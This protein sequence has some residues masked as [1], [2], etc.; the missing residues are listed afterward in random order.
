MPNSSFVA[1]HNLWTESQHE[2]AKKLLRQ[3]KD[4]GIHTVRVA[5]PDQHGILRGKTFTSAVFEQLL[6]DGVG[7][8]STILLKDTSHRTVFSIWGDA[9][10]PTLEALTGAADVQ[11]I[12]DPD[13]FRVLPWRD[14]TGW[15]ISD[16]YFKDGTPVPFATRAVLKNAL[17][18]LS[19][20]GYEFFS[21]IEL[22]F[23]VYRLQDAKLQHSDC[24][25]PPTPPDVQPIAHGFN[26]L[27]ESVFDQL[28]DV[29]QL[30]RSTL[31]KLGLP[32]RSMEAEFGPSQFELTF[33][34]ALGCASADNVI[35][36]RSAIKQVCRRHGYHA[37]FM[38]RPHLPNAFA[39]GWHL[40]QSLIETKTG[41]NAF[42]SDDGD[43]LSPV[44]K[45]FLAGLLEHGRDACIFAAPTINGY[46]RY[47][48]NSLAPNQIVW[49]KDNRGAM[50]RL[51]GEP[52][53]K[54][55]HLENRAGDP[56]ANPY[57]Y[58]ASQVLSGLDGI[59][60][61]LEPPAAVDTPYAKGQRALPNNLYEAIDALEKSEY[62]RNAIGDTFVDYYVTLK[63]AE[64][65][66]FLSEEVTDWE[67]REYFELF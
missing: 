2:S 59:N 48:P 9:E 65:N 44:G 51:I 5:F 12:V 26:Y 17:S 38:S 64:L 28:D 10:N 13:T 39:N 43:A 14:G 53:D 1:K 42:A 11:L 66:R 33:D 24:T 18:V 49:G 29:M 63:K 21:G 30:L 16:P 27:T 37:S 23:A 47:R 32:V 31:D 67:H 4:D 62:F 15:V 25:Q 41:N 20:K 50:L 60:R 34:P 57:L 40:H 46:K 7:L 19:K 54:A 55:T 61:K 52:G 3:L 36:L 58:M 8:T 6:Y 45:Q 35:L 56:T 22:E